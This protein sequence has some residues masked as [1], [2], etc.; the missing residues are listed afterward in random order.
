MSEPKKFY[1]GLEKLERLAQLAKEANMQHHQARMA[2]R[3]ALEHA[4]QAGEA[5]DEAYR[6][7]GRRKK[8]GRWRRENFDGSAETARV[9]RRI[10]REWNHPRL[11]QAR[12]NGIEL[13]SISTVL[14][15]LRGK[16]LPDGTAKPAD[17]VLDEKRMA[18]RRQFAAELRNLDGVEVS[19]FHNATWE[20]LQSLLGEVR[21]AVCVATECNYYDTEEEAIRREDEKREVRGRISRALN[22]GMG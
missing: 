8:W 6:I 17:V 10:A 1:R 7:L 20:L 2:W 12:E 15:V 13:D 19:V 16:K 9:Y 4:R 14:K 5:L 11:V 18:I 3:G 21:H 22:R